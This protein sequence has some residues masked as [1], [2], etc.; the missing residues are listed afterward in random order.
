MHTRE[1]YLKLPIGW[2]PAPE[3]DYS[4]HYMWKKI[5]AHP[6]F[7]GVTSKFA[8]TAKFASNLRVHMSAKERE[9]E[10]SSFWEEMKN[11]NFQQAWNSKVS[12]S[13]LMSAFEFHVDLTNSRKQ[14]QSVQR[15]LDEREN[16]IIMLT[17]K[18]GVIQK[19]LEDKHTELEKLTAHSQ[20]IQQRLEAREN[21]IEKLE[22]NLEVSRA[23]SE[24][25]RDRLIEIANSWSWRMMSI[26]R[27]IH[28][29]LG[30]FVNSQ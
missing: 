9:F 19:G 1:L 14:S 20:V 3:S 30:K 27:K 18:L 21:L 24:F 10:I 17:N 8:T 29:I 5:F 12:E 11:P 23:D 22:V 7:K 26:P 4:D 2:S 28:S 6:D 15:T 16:Q 25:Q 13:V